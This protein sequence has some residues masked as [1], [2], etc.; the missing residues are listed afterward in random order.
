MFL[1]SE[2]TERI[3]AWQVWNKWGYIQSYLSFILN[4]VAKLQNSFK[5]ISPNESPMKMYF[6]LF[7]TSVTKSAIRF[8]IWEVKDWNCLIPQQMTLMTQNTIHCICF[9]VYSSSSSLSTSLWM[10]M[11]S[12]VTSWTLAS[13][14]L[15]EIHLVS[16]RRRDMSCSSSV[17]TRM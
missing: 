17:V 2:G 3:T 5:M 12:H 8:S 11:L 9:H 10:P 1:K 15:I 6:F 4:N 13:N 14:G 16:S 7:H